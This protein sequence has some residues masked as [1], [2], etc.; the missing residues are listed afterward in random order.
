VNLIFM[1]PLKR[2]PA[3]VMENAT[4]AASTIGELLTMLGY[5]DDQQRFI[6][7][8]ADGIR[9][10]LNDPLPETAEITLLLPMGGG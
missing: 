9:L 6:Q 1:G 5:L 7:V 10:D 4:L 8:F 2:P 3:E